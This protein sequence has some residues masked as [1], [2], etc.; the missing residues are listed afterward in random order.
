MPTQLTAFVVMTQR[1]GAQL[2]SAMLGLLALLKDLGGQVV[3][4]GP[5]IDARPGQAPA[6]DGVR[7][8][9]SAS[10]DRFAAYAAGLRLLD[11]ALSWGRIVLLDDSFVT[12]NAQQLFG[13]LD[14][15]PELD[16]ASLTMVVHPRPSLHANWIAFQSPR[17]LQRSSFFDWWGQAAGVSERALTDHFAAAGLRVGSVLRPDRAQCILAVCRALAWGVLPLEVPAAGPYVGDPDLA[18]GLDPRIFL[19][20]EIM[21]RYGIVFLELLRF[22]AHRVN[23]QPLRVWLAANPGAAALVE[24]ALHRQS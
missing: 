19:W 20:D 15:A 18:L 6:M 21:V 13:S 8:A 10:E 3:V 7:W 23:V 17:T 1:A 16:V 22:R 9:S 12:L 11:R 2:T 5:R 24:D 4:A 14:A